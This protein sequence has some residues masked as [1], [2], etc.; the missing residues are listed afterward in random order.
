MKKPKAIVLSGLGINCEQ[1]TQNALQL[2]G[3]IAERVHVNDFV[4][5]KTSLPDCHLLVF[6]G[7]FSFGDDLGSGRVLATKLKYAV[8]NGA[9][10]QKQLQQFIDDGKLVLGICNGFQVMIKLGLLPAI[11]G[12]YFE[13]QATLFLND[14]GRFEDRWVYLKRNEKSN[15]V[16]SKGIKGLELPVRHGEGK[17]VTADKS[18][19]KKIIENEQIAFQ[20]A[21]KN[22]APTMEYPLNPN[23]SISSIAALS[24]ETGRLLGIMPHPESHTLFYNHP[25][26]TRKKH[27]L[28]KQGKTV[29]D[30]G[31]GLQIFRNAF[32][33]ATE[34][35][36]Q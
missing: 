8:A 5:G 7:G 4:A 23:G 26:W 24:D 15:S 28:E 10:I 11:G 14:S 30:E 9:S 21:D 17:I 12:K 33:Y 32:K 1:E 29:P 25:Q 13:Q 16:F 34:K 27:F 22:F 31:E 36:V 6:P 18:V 3:F 20:Y 19:L 2:A 35:L